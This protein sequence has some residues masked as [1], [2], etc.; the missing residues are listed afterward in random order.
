MYSNRNLITEA[1][2][3]LMAVEF[4]YDGY[5]RVYWPYVLG[6]MKSGELELFGWQQKSGK[7]GKPDFR[8]FRLNNLVG[9]I[10]TAQH[11]PKPIPPVNSAERGFLRVI[12]Q[13]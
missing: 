7:G 5:H 10:A 1:I 13:A 2:R 3:S 8:Q 11:F 9:L 4:S 6:E 12:A